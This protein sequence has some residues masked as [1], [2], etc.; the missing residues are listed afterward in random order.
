MSKGL[1]LGDIIVFKAEPEDWLS[2]SIA[3]FSGSDT[4]H[5]AMLYRENAIIEMLAKGVCVHEAAIHEGQEA[6][7]VRLKHA[8]DAEPLLAAA[9]V[10]RRA[11]VKYDFPA[12]FLLAGLFIFRKIPHNKKLMVIGSK[13]L[14]H[15]IT[16]LD[17]IIHHKILHQE[18]AFMVCSQFV[19]QIYYDCRPDYLIDVDYGYQGPVG[20]YQ[21]LAGEHRDPA[22]EHQGFANAAPASHMMPAADGICLADSL[23][24]YLADYPDG[25]PNESSTLF[26][27][28]M[29]Q[30]MA[31]NG[32]ESE[33]FNKDGI[34]EQFY[35]E[36][37]L[38]E[39][40]I[41]NDG[42]RSAAEG[43]QP[44]DEVLHLAGLFLAKTRKILADI[45]TDI[46]VNALFVTPG[47]FVRH[48]RNLEL[49]TL[50][51]LERKI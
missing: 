22:G 15:V 17:Q 23:D 20:E 7:V 32:R 29:N 2:K 45:G 47:D 46:P 37:T 36:L 3:W 39:R 31:V 38:T 21:G 9:D 14:M 8:P 1:K 41:E 26:T 27:G 34:L 28:G 5:A 49:V 48:A 43:G 44:F 16:E 11:G 12:L 24:N 35:Q 10:Y 30:G 13:I 18:G 4:S 50:I 42:L 51:N 25:Y 33:L 19:Y 6:Y 40:A